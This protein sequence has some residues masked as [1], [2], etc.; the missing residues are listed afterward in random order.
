MRMGEMHITIPSPNGGGGT[1]V[2][3]KRKAEDGRAVVALDP[4]E[5]IKV[6]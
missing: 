6:S 4:P 1:E 2:A 5:V 3:K